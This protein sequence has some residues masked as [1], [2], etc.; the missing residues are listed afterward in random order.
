MVVMIERPWRCDVTGNP[1]GTDTRMVG[2]PPCDCQG[3]RAEETITS[4]STRLAEAEQQ[5]DAAIAQLQ[6][7]GDVA[8][9]LRRKLEEHRKALEALADDLTEVKFG[10][11]VYKR[12]SLSK[13][14]I[15]RVVAEIRR[16][17]TLSSGASE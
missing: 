3:C 1:V 16:I 10:D 14:S 11:R 4:L 9:H 15:A 13:D 2:A 12:T 8:R 17:A 5:R 7:T 6:K